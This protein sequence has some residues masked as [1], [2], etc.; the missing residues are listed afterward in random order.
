MPDDFDGRLPAGLP[1]VLGRYTLLRALGAG[2]MGRVYLGQ[3]QDGTQTAVKVLKTDDVERWRFDREVA[4]LSG[5][6]GDAVAKY[7]D[8]DLEA[9][10]PW[11]AMEYLSGMNLRQRIERHGPLSQRAAATV[12][13]RLSGGLSAL[14]RAGIA[15]RDL[16]PGNIM[17]RETGDPVIIDFGLAIDTAA[18]ATD[19][20]TATRFVVGSEH[21]IAPE[22]AQGDRSNLPRADL[23]SLGATIAYAA[24][25]V[26]PKDTSRFLGLEGVDDPLAGILRS[27]LSHDPAKRPEAADCAKHFAALAGKGQTLGHS[28]ADMEAELS[29]G[30]MRERSG[31]RRVA[32]SVPNA[33]A[34]ADYLRTAYTKT[35]DL[36]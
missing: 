34:A 26:H 24:T 30:A 10:T 20:R 6:F 18:P 4:V 23:Y 12:G 1:P 13:M 33:K 27:L 25:G 28:V 7:Y 21:W 15:H 8:A 19:D 16:K 3:D 29:S 14:H 36:V 35:K 11:I 17:I 32:P 9:A 22:Y 31:A 2:A 5:D